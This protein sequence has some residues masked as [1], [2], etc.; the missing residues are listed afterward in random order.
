[1]AAIPPNISPTLRDDQGRASTKYQILI[2]KY[3]FSRGAILATNPV[4]TISSTDKLK[5][6]LKTV[7]DAALFIE[8]I[9]GEVGPARRSGRVRH[10]HNGTRNSGVR[11]LG[12]DC[13]SSCPRCCRQRVDPGKRDGAHAGEHVVAARRRKVRR[14]EADG[15]WPQQRRWQS[16]ID[17]SD[18][19]PINSHLRTSVLPEILPK[20]ICCGQEYLNA[21]DFVVANKE[22]IT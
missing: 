4:T 18:L 8:Q 20:P 3:R 13:D 9:V 21:L 22:R 2:T 7:M 17:F 11:Q 12:G 5:Q 16:G 19:W 10:C 1:M 15:I 6:T 14:A